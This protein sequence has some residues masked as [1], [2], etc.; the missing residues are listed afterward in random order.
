MPLLEK[1]MG[2]FY[3]PGGWEQMEN[4]FH[5][6]RI[7]FKQKKC[8]KQFPGYLHSG[9]F[10]YF[11]HQKLHFLLMRPFYVLL[12]GFKTMHKNIYLFKIMDPIILCL[13]STR[14]EANV[15][16]RWT[17]A[18]YHISMAWGDGRGAESGVTYTGVTCVNTEHKS[19]SEAE[20]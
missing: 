11:W 14:V 15:C 20:M 19:A 7:Q 2:C 12:H 5:T 17:W 18:W 9:P 4:P 8:E 16:K 3:R 1:K 6:C 13:P 10:L